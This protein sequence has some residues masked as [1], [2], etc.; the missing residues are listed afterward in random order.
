LTCYPPGKGAALSF[1]IA[2]RLWALES[3]SL[4][5]AFFNSLSFTQ[6]AGVT[7]KLRSSSPSGRDFD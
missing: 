4:V 3:F 5:S 1:L 2:T 6:L 7:V